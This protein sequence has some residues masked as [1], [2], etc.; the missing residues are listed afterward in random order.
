MSDPYANES[1]SIAIKVYL[2]TSQLE[3]LDR[4][5]YSK[6]SERS[7]FVRS[8]I[9]KAIA[10]GAPNPLEELVA[11]LRARVEALELGREPPEGIGEADQTTLFG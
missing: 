7:Q 4:L 2:G 1:K 11:D 3:D 10:S 5:V 8:L 6:G 9:D